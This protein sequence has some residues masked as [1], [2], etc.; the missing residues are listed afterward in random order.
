M[1][2]FAERVQ[3]LK[4]FSATGPEQVRGVG[5]AVADAQR[6][7]GWGAFRQAEY[8]LRQAEVFAGLRPYT[9]LRRVWD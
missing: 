2:N 7:Y 3:A 9:E 1:D 6:F 4:R 8:V 5:E